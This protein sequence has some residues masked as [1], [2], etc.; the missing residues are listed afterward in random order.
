MVVEVDHAAVSR[1]AWRPHPQHASPFGQFP[2][3]VAGVGEAE[4]GANLGRFRAESDSGPKMK[5]AQL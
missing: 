2:E 1:G 3:H 4:W 5:F